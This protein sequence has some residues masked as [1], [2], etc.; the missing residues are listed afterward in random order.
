LNDINAGAGYQIVER[1][2]SK[3]IYR[4]WEHKTVLFSFQT[5]KFN[6]VSS[7]IPR[8]SQNTRQVYRRYHKL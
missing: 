1:S 6:L 2:D 4:S 3:R 8:T 7:H 5:S